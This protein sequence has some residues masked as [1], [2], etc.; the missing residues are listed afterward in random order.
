[1]FEFRRE[2]YAQPAARGSTHSE[3]SAF[4]P[5]I[6]RPGP[7]PEAGRDLLHTQLARR[8]QSR[9]FNLVGISHP[10]HSAGVEAPSGSGLEAGTVE[11][12][13][14]LSVGLLTAETFGKFDRTRRRSSRLPSRLRPPRPQLLARP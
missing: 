7:N 12:V 5:I 9:R 4:D 11:F 10:T 3:L 1:L 6:E 13:G 8:E 14:Q 2:R